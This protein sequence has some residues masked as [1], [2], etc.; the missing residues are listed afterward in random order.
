MVSKARMFLNAF[1]VTMLMLVI[2]NFVSTYS[3]ASVLPRKIAVKKSL[4][5]SVGQKKTLKVKLKPTKSNTKLCWKSKNSKIA[6]VTKKGIV[7]GKKVGK[8]VITVTAKVKNKKISAKCKINVN[9]SINKI[10]GTV[11]NSSNSITNMPNNTVNN[12]TATIKP[13]SNQEETTN[14][15]N[16]NV[17]HV[18]SIEAT[19]QKTSLIVGDSIQINVKVLP[20]NAKDNTV[21]YESSNTNVATVTESG[22]VNAISKGKSTITIKPKDNTLVSKSF[23]LTV[24]NQ[25]P[26]VIV[27]TDGEFDD[28]NSL[29]HYLLYSNEMDIS[30]IVQS[31][32]KYHWA[33]VEDGE[34]GKYVQGKSPNRWA[35]TKWFYNMMDAYEEVYPN[36]IVHNS[37]YP[38]A[39]YLRSVFVSGN[40]GYEGEMDGPTDGS[41]LIK[42]CILD[43]DPRTL[44]IEAWGGTNTMAMALKQI[45]DEYKGTANWEDIYN[46]VSN[47]II[48]LACNKQDNTYDEYIA[49]SWPKIPF[50]NNECQQAYGYA[51]KDVGSSEM[52][53]TLSSTWMYE[54]IETNHGPLLDLYLTW[55]DGT[56]L[57][58]EPMSLRYGTNDDLLNN[59]D[60]WVGK[61]YDRYDFLSEGDS[62]T[63]FNLLDTGLQTLTL[64]EFAYG[65]YAGRYAKKSAT[66]VDPNSWDLQNDNDKV[67]GL[68]GTNPSVIKWIPDVQHDFAVRADW[69]VTSEYN[70]ANHRPDIF[71]TEG[72][73]I[74]AKKGDSI[75]LNAVTSDPDG[76]NVSVNWW[77][78]IEA[79]TYKS[80]SPIT[81]DGDNTNHISF[82]IPSDAKS[83]DTIHIIARATDDGE[84][85][86]VYHQRIIITVE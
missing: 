34:E 36:L 32:S 3:E 74:T 49:K 29:I 84:H 40:I 2:V 45:E 16:N 75:A 41:N 26:R 66:A 33:G 8:T 10:Q 65:G 68:N 14:I 12:I 79:G 53:K 38:T 69:C 80:K 46:K 63:Y 44:F 22:L 43:D 19:M 42:K 4:T 83:G 78:Y 58:Y 60:W 11:N 13:N 18:S 71:I 6:T 7:K 35:G 72:N 5:I 62:T 51:T 55:G 25:N 85:N 9:K 54:N 20:E 67:L 50:F 37:Y 28:A 81:L 24:I 15:N 48:I 64:E 77:N 82:M 52:K 73:S 56:E 76:D 17:I 39:D 57:P 1:V 61:G 59:S 86:L 31:S 27:T 23:D 47:K 30:G 21:I 70:K